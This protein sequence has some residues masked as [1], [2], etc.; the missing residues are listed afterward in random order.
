MDIYIYENGKKEINDIWETNSFKETSFCNT[1]NQ[2]LIE[3][4]LHIVHR[5]NLIM[6]ILL[7][8]VQIKILVNIIIQIMSF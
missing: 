7:F 6:M 4:H 8:L 2:L 3:I 1:L 5:M